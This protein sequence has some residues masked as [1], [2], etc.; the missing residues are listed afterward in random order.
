MEP[1]TVTITVNDEHSQSIV[2]T[3]QNFDTEFKKIRS[4]PEPL[5]AVGDVMFCQTLENRKYARQLRAELWR[6]ARLYALRQLQDELL[7]KE[8]TAILNQL[9]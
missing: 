8:M 5:N 4:N 6:I 2:F 7:D 3:E 9:D 1:I